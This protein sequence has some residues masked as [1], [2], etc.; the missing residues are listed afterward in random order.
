MF[1]KELVYLVL[2][3]LQVTYDGSSK[4]CLQYDTMKEHFDLVK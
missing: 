1:P 2:S 3:S 4:K